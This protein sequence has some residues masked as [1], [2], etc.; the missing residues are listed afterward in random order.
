MQLLK[1][2]LFII[3]LLFL[4][5]A[6]LSAQ[7]SEGPTNS[8]EKRW[9]FLHAGLGYFKT[10]GDWAQRYPTHLSV[11]LAIEYSHRSNWSLGADFSFFLG[12]NVN[13]EGLYGNMTNDSGVL[14]DMNGFPAVIRTYQRGYSTRVFALKNWILAR[15]RNSRLLLQTGGGIGYYTHYTKFTFD[16]D[17]LPQIDGNFQGGYNRHTQG[18]QLFEQ[19]RL[20]YINNDA[21]SF[22][23]GFEAGQGQ[24]SRLHP[25]DF[26][27]QK[28]NSGTVTDTYWGGNFSIMIPINYR[29]RITE[30]DY[31]ME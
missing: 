11:P 29:D 10:G 19:I 13:E 30:V 26:A 3:T 2:N 18:T 22:T 21:I 23:L 4:S 5:G 17:Q 9:F 12:S 24:G 27:T 31:Y 15:S 16:I 7:L 1:R 6:P 28:S 20:Q 25:Y 8:Q 14:I